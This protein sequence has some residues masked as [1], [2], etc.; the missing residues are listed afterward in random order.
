VVSCIE[1]DSKHLDA[2]LSA[3]KEALIASVADVTQQ[4][5]ATE[6]RNR[7]VSRAEAAALACR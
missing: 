1:G 7:S 4:I 5:L 6:V 3:R 2:A